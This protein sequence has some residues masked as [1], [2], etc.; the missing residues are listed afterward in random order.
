MSELFIFRQKYIF[1]IKDGTFASYPLFSPK[2]PPLAD[3]GVNYP[4]PKSPKYGSYVQTESPPAAQ[5]R[6]D[7][8]EDILDCMENESDIVI[9]SD[10]DS[11]N[12]ILEIRRN[13]LTKRRKN[14]SKK[15]N[16]RAEKGSFYNCY[17]IEHFEP[18]TK[19][20]FLEKYYWKSLTLCIQ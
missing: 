9:I 13:L 12:N 3:Q 18:K 15:Q 5:P 10:S 14:F 7:R 16:Q 11:D 2:S 8:E 1:P 20:Y 19:L 17:L 6:S 4:A